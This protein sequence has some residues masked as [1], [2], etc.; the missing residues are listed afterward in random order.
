M[1][2]VA[3]SSKERTPPRQNQ[4]KILPDAKTSS[5][6][7]DEHQ[8]GRGR[9]REEWVADVHPAPHGPLDEGHAAATGVRARIHPIVQAFPPEKTVN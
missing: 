5:R 7:M 2:N 3:R 9:E 8:R 1:Q 6:P 4:D